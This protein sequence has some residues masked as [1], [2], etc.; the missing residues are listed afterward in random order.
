M[1]KFIQI[2]KILKLNMSSIYLIMS[3]SVFL[4]R[5]L[6]INYISRQCL[7]SQ[8]KAGKSWINHLGNFILKFV[9]LITSRRYY[10]VTEGITRLKTKTAGHDIYSFL[11]NRLK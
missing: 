4:A 3:C 5:N 1:M 8:K 6:I 10:G 9:L 2:L 11:I 7:F